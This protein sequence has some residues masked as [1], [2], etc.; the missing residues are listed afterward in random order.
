MR[1]IEDELRRQGRGNTLKVRVPFFARGIHHAHVHN[2]NSPKDE[3]GRSTV[4]FTQT[5]L[6]G[7]AEQVSVPVHEAL[8]ASGVVK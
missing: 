5:F 1:S 4:P 6:L 8:R 3:M 2:P 7:R